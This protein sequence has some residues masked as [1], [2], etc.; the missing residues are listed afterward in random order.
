MTSRGDGR[1]AIFLGEE[2]RRLFLGMLSEVVPDFNWAVPIS[3]T[4]VKLI[5]TGCGGNGHPIW[6]SSRKQDGAATLRWG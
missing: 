6:A 4:S 2:D 1:E 5:G 3:V